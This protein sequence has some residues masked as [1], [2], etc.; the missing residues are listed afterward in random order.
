[1]IIADDNAVIIR[2]MPV[3]LRTSQLLPFKKTPPRKEFELN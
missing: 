1:M 2:A 3:N